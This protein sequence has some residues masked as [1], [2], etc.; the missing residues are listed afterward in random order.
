LHPLKDEGVFAHPHATGADHLT[1]APVPML[2]IVR[3]RIV[4]GDLPRASSSV[5]KGAVFLLVNWPGTVRQAARP[6]K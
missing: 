6:S 5:D 1:G 2:L 3:E 4:R